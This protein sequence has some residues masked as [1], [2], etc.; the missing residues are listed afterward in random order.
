M[1]GL[2]SSDQLPPPALLLITFLTIGLGAIELGPA[3]AM[4]TLLGGASMCLIL[5]IVLSIAL[6]LV[7]GRHMLDPDR[8]LNLGVW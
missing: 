2:S 3:T 8:L 6:A 5:Y 7:R 4:N 1:S